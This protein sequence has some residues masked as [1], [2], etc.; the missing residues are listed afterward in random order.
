ME[1]LKPFGVGSV[2]V[3]KRE[4][5]FE[6]IFPPALVTATSFEFFRIFECP[7]KNVPERNVGEVISMMTKLVVNP[8]RLRALKN[9]T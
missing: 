7:E 9:V 4:H 1:R 5:V 3:P 2:N 8:V 6:P